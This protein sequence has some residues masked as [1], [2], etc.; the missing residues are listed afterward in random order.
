MKVVELLAE[1]MKIRYML[2]SVKLY[3]SGTKYSMTKHNEEEICLAKQ[4][5][6]DNYE[7]VQKLLKKTD[8]LNDALHKSD[9]KT[10]IQVMGNKMRVATA[11]QYLS[12]FSHVDY[13]CMAGFDPDDFPYYGF[14]NFRWSELNICC[15]HREEDVTFDPLSLKER[16]AE[17]EEEKID[18]YL[19]L[20]TAV[21]ISDAITEVEIED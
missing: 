16:G 19:G 18:W 21:A 15:I 12:E 4:R 3:G 10:Y 2:T 14:R 6:E 20:R 8:A 13:D 1:R 7:F 11:R 9:A 5:I 17:F